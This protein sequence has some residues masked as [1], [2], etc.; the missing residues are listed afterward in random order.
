MAEDDLRLA[1]QAARDG[2]K[3]RRDILLTLAAAAGGTA[4]APWARR[5]RDWLVAARPDHPFARTPTL[6]QARGDPRVVA[7][8]IRLRKIYPP[9]RVR[10]LLLR[11]AASRGPYTGRSIALSAILDDL[12]GAPPPRPRRR[13]RSGAASRSP[14]DRPRPTLGTVI[15]SQG[16]HRPAGFAHP[17]SPPAGWPLSSPPST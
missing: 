10:W 12:F 5:A 17:T 15:R 9:P 2:H 4:C 3:G 16:D 14:G 11:S 6:E 8:L 1:W 7:L 13:S